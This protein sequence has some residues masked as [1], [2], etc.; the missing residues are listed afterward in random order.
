MKVSIVS[1]HLVVLYVKMLTNVFM[2]VISVPKTHFVSTY[3]ARTNALI[4]VGVWTARTGTSKFDMIPTVNVSMLMN[5]SRTVVRREPFVKI[6][7]ADTN[8][9]TWMSANQSR[10][11]LV[12]TVLILSDHFNANQSNVNQ[13]RTGSN[14]V[15]GRSESR[16]VSPLE[17]ATFGKGVANLK[18][19]HDKPTCSAVCEDDKNKN[20]FCP[21]GYRKDGLLCHKQN[22]CLTNQGGCDQIWT[23]DSAKDSVQCSCNEGYNLGLCFNIAG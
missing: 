17:T 22:P 4:H 15:R 7:K 21:K 18:M 13:I 5:V 3:Q 1:I 12:I 20:C 16:T 9:L 6:M 14:F 23:F 8:V 11:I 19:N 10:V 2:A